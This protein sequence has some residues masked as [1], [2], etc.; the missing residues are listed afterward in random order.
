MEGFWCARQILQR[1]WPILTVRGEG[2]LDLAKLDGNGLI[3]AKRKGGEGKHKFTWKLEGDNPNYVINFL[4][5]WREFHRPKINRNLVPEVERQNARQKW[6]QNIFGLKRGMIFLAATIFLWSQTKINQ[7][8]CK[9]EA[10]AQ[11]FVPKDLL[12][13][14]ICNQ[15]WHKE[16]R[17]CEFIYWFK[18]EI[19]KSK[20]RTN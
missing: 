13:F 7:K 4:F 15:K 9:R 19:C 3:F 16:G 1:G 6:S 12:A 18:S 17:Q 5:L 2:E 8:L 11:T 20:R 14:G 10:G